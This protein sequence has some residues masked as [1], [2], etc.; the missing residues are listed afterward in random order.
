MTLE[1]IDIQLLGK[2]LTIKGERS[3]TR[4]ETVTHHRR[5]RYNG[6]FERELT[7]PVEIDADGVKADLRDGVLT[8]TLPKAAAARARK[9]EVNFKAN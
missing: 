7:I 3:A 1:A 6:S 2:K 5:E 9:I 8:V 4:D